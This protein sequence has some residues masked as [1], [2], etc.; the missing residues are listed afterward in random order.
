MKT[1]STQFKFLD[2]DPIFKSDININ[3]GD[4][5]H[6]SILSI[7]QKLYEGMLNDQMLD[8]FHEIFDILLSANR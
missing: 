7:L 1:F 5:R 8:H 3:K 2:V 6:V 4:F